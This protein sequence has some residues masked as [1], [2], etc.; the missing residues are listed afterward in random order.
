MLLAACTGINPTAAML[1]GVWGFL[2]SHG[3]HSV[4]VCMHAQTVL[5]RKKGG[6]VSMC[7]QGEEIRYHPRSCTNRGTGAGTK[8][9][10]FLM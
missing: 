2:L 8:R 10:E 1:Y 4:S 3:S 9:R 6:L 5:K 7:Q